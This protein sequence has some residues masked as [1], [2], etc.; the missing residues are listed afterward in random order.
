VYGASF[1]RFIE[2]GKKDI[3][4]NKTIYLKAFQRNLSYFALD[5]DRLV[6]EKPKVCAKVM[7]ELL[8]L[9]EKSHYHALP[10]RTFEFLNTRMAMRYLSQAKHVIANGRLYDQ[11]WGYDVCPTM[12]NDRVEE[13]RVKTGNPLNPHFRIYA[14]DLQTTKLC[15]Q[16]KF[17]PWNKNTGSPILQLFRLNVQ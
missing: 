13:D 10:H 15:C 2:I 16:W 6:M 3:E 12:S 5:T 17:F 1:G 7:R 8:N 9:Y 4:Q 11:S 14:P